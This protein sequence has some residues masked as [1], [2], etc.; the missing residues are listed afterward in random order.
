MRPARALVLLPLLLAVALP[1]GATAPAA[2][3]A[4]PAEP[5]PALR[6][7]AGSVAS[8]RIVAVG[9]DVTVAGEA[10]AGVTALDGDAIISGTVTGDVTV[11]GG[12]VELAPTA[13]VAG[14]IFVLGGELH[15]SPGARLDGRSVVYP[16]ISRAW[17]T[18]LEGPS[19]GLSAGA[20][21]V[22]A[23]K[24]ALVAAWLAL[25]LLLFATGSR[26]VVATSEELRLDPFSCFAAGLVSVL[27]ATMTTLFLS[28]LLPPLVAVPLLALV[29]LAALLAKLWGMVAVFHATGALLARRFA[30]RRRLLALHA[31]V[32][33]LVVL[34]AIKFLPFVGLWVWTGATFLGVGAALRSKFGRHEAWFPDALPVS[35]APTHS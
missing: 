17:M 33:G 10:L 3:A 18:L 13:R 12:S 34:A 22:V 9:R 16:S 19:L 8:H 11:I 23:A 5:P 1:A 24:L 14:E 35:S 28:S 7:D 30:G 29:V 27:A 2:T 4:P 21:V 25:T 31:G 6:L 15:A 26:S 20:P 32:A